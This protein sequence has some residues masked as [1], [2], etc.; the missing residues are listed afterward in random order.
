MFTRCLIDGELALDVLFA[1][2]GLPSSAQT[3]TNAPCHTVTKMV[4]G[5]WLALLVTK[6]TFSLAQ[7]PSTVATS[8][9]WERSKGVSNAGSPRLQADPHHLPVARTRTPNLQLFFLCQQLLL[10]PPASSVIRAGDS[11]VLDD[12]PCFLRGSSRAIHVLVALPRHLSN[13]GYLFFLALSPSS[14]G[15]SWKANIQAHPVSGPLHVLLYSAQPP[16]ESSGP[17]DCG[18]LHRD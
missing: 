9:S 1:I 4:T 14:A 8:S 17:P 18:L 3:P 12:Y 6:S 13:I 5:V 2:R 11:G 16:T 15:L 10:E 7:P